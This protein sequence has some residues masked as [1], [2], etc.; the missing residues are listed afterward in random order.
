[1]ELTITKILKRPQQPQ[2]KD[3]TNTFSSSNL[4]QLCRY[5]SHFERKKKNG[6]QKMG[7]FVL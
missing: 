4:L 5:I 2:Y 3:Y 7:H 1:M 6:I